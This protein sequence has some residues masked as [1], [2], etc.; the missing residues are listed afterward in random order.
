MAGD[1][2]EARGRAVEEMLAAGFIMGGRATFDI[3]ARLIAGKIKGDWRQAFYKNP[4]KFYKALVE[5]VGG[6]TMAYMVLRMATKRLRDLGIQVE[7]TE[8]IDALKKGDRAK[9]LRIVDELAVALELV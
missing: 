5:A 8:I 3:L 9:L 6:E 7:G 1:L 2:E 4:K